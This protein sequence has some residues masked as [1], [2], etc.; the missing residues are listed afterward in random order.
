[1]ERGTPNEEVALVT[2]IP[3]G[4]HFTATRGYDGTTAK[5]HAINMP[6]EHCVASIDY[7][8]ANAHINDPLLHQSA[9]TGLVAPFAGASTAVP[10][11][12]ILCD[13][14]AVSRTT[15]ATLHALLKDAAGVNSYPFGAGD[16]VNT[17]NVPDLRGR[18]ALGLD[19][20]GGTSANR[21]T[22]TQADVVGGAAGV[23]TVALSINEMPTHTH[24][25]NAHT[26]IQNA[27]THIQNA[28]NHVQDA[29]SHAP[30]GGGIFICWTEGAFNSS[31]G[32]GAV[33]YDGY[34]DYRQPFI[35]NTTATNQ[36]TTPT[37]QNT[38]GVNQ[39]AGGGTAHQ[40]MPPFLGLNWIVKA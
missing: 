31:F 13:G 14:R 4:T 12:W 25:Q 9:P 40:N 35:Y 24:L 5:A 8:E 2:A 30:N 18:M 23:E 27:H 26:H 19:N 39:N 7:D 28:H 10:A 21:V 15:Y 1:M 29:H 37:N 20:M 34:T 33:G 38:T 22:A 16:G 32:P 6:V 11:E 36:Y 3:D 17:F